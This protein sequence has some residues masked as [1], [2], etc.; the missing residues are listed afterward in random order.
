MPMMGC[1]TSRD[2]TRKW[3]GKCTADE[4]PKASSASAAGCKSVAR[5][6]KAGERRL[7]CF[8]DELGRTSVG[9]G[10]HQDGFRVARRVS[11]AL[12]EA[13]FEA[14]RYVEVVRTPV[15]DDEEVGTIFSL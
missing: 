8:R 3:Q 12:G 11:D 6:S 10:G 9:A 5:A 2:C 13:T 7:H 14:G 15:D 1:F 4:G